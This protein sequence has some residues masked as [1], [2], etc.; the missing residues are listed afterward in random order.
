MLQLLHNSCLTI[1]LYEYRICRWQ[2]IEEDVPRNPEF[3]REDFTVEVLP[4]VKNVIVPL[5]EDGYSDL[6]YLAYDCFHLSQK[7][8]SM[9][10]HNFN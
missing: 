4:G 3:H 9:C 2:K 5:A 7:A 6:S 1:I 10:K 8:H